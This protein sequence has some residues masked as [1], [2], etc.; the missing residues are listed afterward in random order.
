[1]TH[2]QQRSAGGQFLVEELSPANLFTPE[3]FT[4]EHKMISKLAHDFVEKEVLPVNEWLENHEF[5]LLVSLLKKAGGLGLLAHSVPEA[6]DGLGLDKITK[7]LVSEAIGRTGGYGVAHANHTCI[8]TLPVTYFG[9]PEQ[10]AKYLPKLASGDFLGAYCLTEPS[11]GSD[12]LGAKTTAWLNEAGT[13]YLLNGT[14]QFIT[15]ASFADTFI[16]Y[17]KVDGEHFTAFMVEKDMPGLSIGAEEQK[18]GIKGSSTCQ[19]FFEDCEVPVENVLG[20]VGRGHTIAFNVLN[21]GRFNLG[22]ATLGGAKSALREG[23]LY[24]KQRQQFGR[25]LTA[26]PATQE[27]LATIAARLYACESL[28]YRTA[29]LLEGA[30]HDKG[31][32]DADKRAVAKSLMEYA[33]ECS[34]CKVFG[35]ETLDLAV[36]EVLQLHGGYGYIK[37]YPIERMYRDSR[38]NRIFEGSNEINRLLVPGMLAR[39]AQTGELPFAEKAQAAFAELQHPPEAGDGVLARE[40]EMTATVR[41]AFLALSGLAFETYKEKLDREQELVMRLSE[42]AITLYAMESAVVRAVKAVEQKGA[43][44]AAAHLDLA[45]AFVD[46]ALLGAE[47]L[48]RQLIGAPFAVDKAPLFLALIAANFG[49]FFPAGQI[50]RKRRIAGRLIKA[51]RYEL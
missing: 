21:L 13:H 30:L 35:S 2:V 17:A 20:D 15:N 19:V 43:E 5:D 4:D 9:T 12:A 38:I 46:D 51:E 48:V 49:R 28:L 44:G 25:A 37:D 16:V 10:K 1:M 11:A 45:A 42:L 24:T 39:K 26:F 34:I 7:A 29:D 23:L 32:D 18:M 33:I 3:D 41:R 36:D 50:E 6:Y 40:R 22:A 47:M 14:K 27:K 8:A 31:E